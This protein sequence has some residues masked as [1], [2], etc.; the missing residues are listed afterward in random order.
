M[1]FTIKKQ[2]S[3]GRNDKTRLH[4]HSYRWKDKL[5]HLFLIIISPTTFAST[6]EP[7][8]LIPSS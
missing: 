2:C 8:P 4:F 7:N 3:R 6:L 1:I 5:H